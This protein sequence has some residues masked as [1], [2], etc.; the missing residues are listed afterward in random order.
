MGC[1]AKSA[2]G[3]G[4]TVAAGIVVV[5]IAAAVENIVHPRK[6]MPTNGV[7]SASTASPDQSASDAQQ[8]E[9]WKRSVA[10]HKSDTPPEVT[11]TASPK[12]T[13]RD[14]QELREFLRKD[15]E[16]TVQSDNMHLNYI[17]ARY[18]KGPGDG[19]SLMAVH[20]Y[21]GR[22]TLSIGPTAHEISAWIDLNRPELEQAHVRRVGVVS[23]DLGDSSWFDL[24]SSTDDKKPH[25]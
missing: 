21:F 20:P 5:F 10:E 1:L 18:Q 24:V 6:P 7:A 19:V 14:M 16:T 25:K 4:F 11:P 23:K 15:Y 22:Y 2:Q 3:C 8:V 9:A 12:A 13:K 17:T